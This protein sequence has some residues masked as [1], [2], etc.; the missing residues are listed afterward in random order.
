MGTYYKVFRDSVDELTLTWASGVLENIKIDSKVVFNHHT[1]FM[2]GFKMYFEY[3]I[4]NIY[5]YTA[6]SLIDNYIIKKS[7]YRIYIFS[8][9]ISLMINRTLLD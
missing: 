8:L 7:T 6:G 3:I 9:T 1:M 2:C 4:Y 5:I